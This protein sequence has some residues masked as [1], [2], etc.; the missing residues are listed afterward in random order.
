MASPGG[1]NSYLRIS[2][3]SAQ[4][5]WN[6]FQTNCVCGGVRC[7]K[8]VSHYFLFIAFPPPPPAP[9]SCIRMNA[10]TH[11]PSLCGSLALSACVFLCWPFFLSIWL[12]VL[13]QDIHFSLSC[14]PSDRDRLWLAFGLKSLDN[15]IS[16]RD[17]PGLLC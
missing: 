8:S 3:S 13:F 2:L 10:D 12:S 16:V 7:K 17:A 14:F 15:Q 6:K 5:K 1:L 11:V 9:V 4:K